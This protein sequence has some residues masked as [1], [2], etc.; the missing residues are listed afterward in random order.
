MKTKIL[1][2]S[3]FAIATYSAGAFAVS[4]NTISFQGEVTDQTCS[5]SI[6]GD[7]KP[8][9]L[10]P[11]VS[12]KTLSAVGVSAGTATFDI[13]VNGCDAATQATQI[14]TVFSGNMVDTANKGTLKN[15]GTA[16]NVNLQL[17]DVD[18][19]D[20]DL[21]ST[22]KSEKG[23][24]SLDVGDTEKT[25]TYSVQYYATGQATAGTVAATVEYAISYL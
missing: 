12:T 10:L 16:K 5:V 20:I 14:K 21:S 8:V 2:S 23:D 13:S 25:A 4:D 9:I 7:S 24:L 18:G 1:L 3:A 6:N 22:W 15:T 19:K 17:L 11:T